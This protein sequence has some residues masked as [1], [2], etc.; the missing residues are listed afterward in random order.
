MFAD[1]AQDPG[2]AQLR[3]VPG[4]VVRAHTRNRHGSEQCQGLARNRSSNPMGG[5]VL[6][7]RVPAL[8]SFERRKPRRTTQKGRSPMVTQAQ[9]RLPR[10][11][12]F[13]LWFNPKKGHLKREQESGG[14]L[15]YSVFGCCYLRREKK[16]HSNAWHTIPA[17]QLLQV[18]IIG[19]KKHE[20]TASRQECRSSASSMPEKLC[21][22]VGAR[23]PIAKRT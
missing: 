22:P 14:P 13:A 6:F 18:D 5:G 11:N 4:D 20:A 15:L 16:K 17:N 7:Y 3:G 2:P 1:T 9:I 10:K 21:I 19:C 8:G 23:R 12:G